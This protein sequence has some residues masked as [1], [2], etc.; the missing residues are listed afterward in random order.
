MIFIHWCGGLSKN[1]PQRLRYLNIMKLL[2]LLGKVSRY[3]PKGRIMS[4][5]QFYE[6]LQHSPITNL[7]SVFLT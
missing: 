2:E 4:L 7:F 6:N 5:G 3:S 1:A